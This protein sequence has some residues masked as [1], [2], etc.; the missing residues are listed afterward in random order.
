M[1]SPNLRRQLTGAVVAVVLGSISATNA[2]AVAWT[3]ATGANTSF[4][5][6][7]G[8]NNIGLYGDP[9][10]TSW[11]FT[12]LDTVNYRA[13]G[14][15][16]SGGFASDWTRVTTDVATAVPAPGA[17][18]QFIK[19]VEWGF[20][21]TGEVGQPMHPDLDPSDFSALSTFQVFRFAPAPTGTTGALVVPI[22]FNPDG[23]WMA[24]RVLDG[25]VYFATTDPTE[26][27]WN[28]A[29]LRV[30]N[31]LQ[32]LGTAPPGSFIEKAGMNIIVPEPTTVFFLVAGLGS[33]AL[34]RSRR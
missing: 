18:M 28:R 3:N 2:W 5:W 15:G 1:R 9:T 26:T 29:Q 30:D 10:V 13:T 19:V 24:E 17:S 4:G 21:G 6:A 16:G 27:W 11:G 23:T 31:S 34:R 25:D 22:T 7:S 8:M 32:V 20:W 12:F 33:L 14:G